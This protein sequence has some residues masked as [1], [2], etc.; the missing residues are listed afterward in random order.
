[1]SIYINLYIYIP[2]AQTN[3]DTQSLQQLL[4]QRKQR[5]WRP[6]RGAAEQ[7]LLGKHGA[8]FL[9]KLLEAII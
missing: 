1:M 6:E 2:F 4:D 7:H 3:L 8:R 9:D 5:R